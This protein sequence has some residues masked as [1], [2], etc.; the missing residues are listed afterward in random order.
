[1]NIIF[2]FIIRL[3]KKFISPL[4]PPSCIYTPSC[5]SYAIEALNKH[6][7]VQGLI[8]SVKR[9]FRCHPW[10]KGGYDPVPE[11]KDNE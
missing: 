1:M 2:I 6:G 11:V 5:S 4:L 3:Y 8:L 7:T 9:V 10:H